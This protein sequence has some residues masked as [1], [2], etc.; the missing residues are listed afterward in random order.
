MREKLL[1]SIVVGAD[2]VFI[3]ELHY[4]CVASSENKHQ[5]HDAIKLP[6][7]DR[8]LFLVVRHIIFKILRD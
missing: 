3:L 5:N 4:D 7:G 6:V 1:A 8:V 2:L